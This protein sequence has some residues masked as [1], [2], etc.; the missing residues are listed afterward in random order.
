MLDGVQ[1]LDRTGLLLLA[2]QHLR[3]APMAAGERASWDRADGQW[4]NAGLVQL[5]CS[6]E[7][8]G[9][10]PLELLTSINAYGDSSIHL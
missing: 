1:P 4:M 8:G 9:N 2:T 10:V 3:G 6:A 5:G 7:E